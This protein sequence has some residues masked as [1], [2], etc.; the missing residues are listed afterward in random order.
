MP[1]LQGQAVKT[2]WW[3]RIRGPDPMPATGAQRNRRRRK[4]EAALGIVE[5]VPYKLLHPEAREVVRRV[6]A[7]VDAGTDCLA[8]D[9]W[10]LIR[11]ARRAR[12]GGFRTSAPGSGSVVAGPS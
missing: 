4:L 1:I 7:A 6:R 8:A 9:V 5:D 3:D 10:A 12:C 2:P 11:L